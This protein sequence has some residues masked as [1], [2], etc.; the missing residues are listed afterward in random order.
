[1]KILT[2]EFPGEL[3]KYLKTLREYYLYKHEV[4]A[5]RKKIKGRLGVLCADV[6]TKFFQDVL[7]GR[8]VK[9]PLNYKQW[10]KTLSKDLKIVLKDIESA[11]KERRKIQEI[12]KSYI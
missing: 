11:A 1:M 4:E 9:K 7:E 3:L 10:K 6:H 5:L 12:N 2:E 8:K